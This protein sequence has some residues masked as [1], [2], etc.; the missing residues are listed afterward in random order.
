MNR[1]SSLRQLALFVAEFAVVLIG[2]WTV[3]VAWQLW[4]AL[5]SAAGE[6]GERTV[7]HRT[8][9]SWRRWAIVGLLCCAVLG[10]GSAFGPLSQRLAAV[11]HA[12]AP[13]LPAPLALLRY[14]L[15]TPAILMALLI[16]STA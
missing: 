4:R 16:A 7:G 12:A 9:V 14:A 1:K 6:A 13:A 11:A 2:I 8:A 15:T 3:R 10:A 5:S